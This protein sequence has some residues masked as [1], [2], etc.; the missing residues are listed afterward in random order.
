[1]LQFQSRGT[2]AAT[3]A[4]D[5]AAFLPPAATAAVGVVLPLTSTPAASEEVALEDWELFRLC[6][7]LN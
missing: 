3:S 1:V 6:Q 2:L 7:A 4:L 5:T